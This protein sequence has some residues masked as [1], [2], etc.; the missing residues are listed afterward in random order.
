MAIPSKTLANGVE[1]PYLGLGVYKMEDHE[2]ALNAMDTALKLGYRAIDTASLYNNEREVG[3]A[4]RAS[5]IPR[6]EIFVTTKVWNNDQG[7]DETLRAFE[8]SLKKLG[9]DYVDLYLTHWP[10]EDKFID[11]YRAIERL[12]E[13]KLIRV[14]GVSNHH[15]HHLEKIFAKANVKPMVNQVECH[16]YLQQDELRA[17]C[18]EHEI[19]VT[20]WSPIGKGRLLNDNTLVKLAEKYGKTPAQIVLRWHYQND[21]I[22]IPK[23]VTPSRIAENMQIFDFEL[24]NEDMLEIKMINKNERYGQNPDN[25]HFDF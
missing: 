7:Y 16:P 2:E 24:S 21:T 18:R 12:Y 23:S 14:P 3:E 17:F 22:T 6:E 9:L 15:Q 19:A 11:T 25:F 13:E 1:M 5:G 10:V 4:I 8:T 20:A